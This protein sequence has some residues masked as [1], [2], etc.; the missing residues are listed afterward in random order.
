MEFWDHVRWNW[1]SCWD[2]VGLKDADG[3]GK[4][5]NRRANGTQIAHKIAYQHYFGPVPAEMVMDHLCRNRACVNP[6][7]LEA[8]T[9]K[10][11]TVRGIHRN[12]KKTHCIRGHEFVPGNYRLRPGWNGNQRRECIL[13][14]RIRAGQQK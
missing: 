5:G 11:N 6:F 13:C 14:A 4:Y 12:A 1:G 3:Y 2:C 10:E 9:A 8:V 7:H